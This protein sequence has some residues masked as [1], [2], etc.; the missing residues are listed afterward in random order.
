M[1]RAA[2]GIDPA[3]RRLRST[4]TI[5]WKIRSPSPPAPIR[6]AKVA[7][8]M[9]NTV[10]VRIPA[11]PL[12]RFD[13]GTVHVDD[14]G[15]GV[16][17]DGEHRSQD[18]GEDGRF[19]PDPQHRDDHAQDGKARNG[20][21]HVGRVDDHGRQPPVPGD[22]DPQGH[23]DEDRQKDGD[24]A[25]FNVLE[26]QEKDLPLPFDN[27]LEKLHRPHPFPQEEP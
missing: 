25:H 26:R 3:S 7:T 4:M 14:P 20:L 21:P 18:Q 1:A 27:E 23:G 2:V 11:H 19:E 15:V 9:L 24:R 12:A 16:V 10:A 13:D 8:L 17:D 5:P 22:Q 6:A